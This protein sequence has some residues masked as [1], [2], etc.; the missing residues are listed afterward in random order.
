MSKSLVLKPTQVE[1]L[2]G[3][4]ALAAELDA[5]HGPGRGGAAG[6]GVPGRG[7]PFT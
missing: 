6:G 5:R 1:G 4:E 7:D 3:L 2:E